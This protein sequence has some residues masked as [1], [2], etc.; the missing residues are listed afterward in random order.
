MPTR[1]SKRMRL[2][3]GCLAVF[4][5]CVLV[6]HAQAQQPLYTPGPPVPTAPGSNAPPPVP[7]APESGAPPA[8]NEPRSAARTHERTSLAKTVHHRRR[9][10]VAARTPPY[11]WRGYWDP[12]APCCFVPFGIIPMTRT[13]VS[14]GG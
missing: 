10:A 5:A 8:V 4:G 9:S 6:A 7:T 2:V 3:G 11:Y 1:R 14:G 13:V 12:W